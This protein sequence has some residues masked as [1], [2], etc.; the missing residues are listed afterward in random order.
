MSGAW[1]HWQDEALILNIRVQTRASRDAVAG[2]YGDQLK[3]CLTAPPV[4]GA[5][6]RKLVRFLADVCDVPLKRIEL[7][8]GFSSRSKRLR[9]DRPKRLP[10]GVAAAHL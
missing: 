5:A 4:D 9:I 3:I 8:S 6:N 1:Y 10:P 7:L 2:P